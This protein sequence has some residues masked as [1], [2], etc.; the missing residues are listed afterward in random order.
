MLKKIIGILIVGTVAVVLVLVFL[1]RGSQDTIVAERPDFPFAPLTDEKLSDPDNPSRTFQLDFARVE[2]EFPV[3][4]ADLMRL[5]PANLTAL[6]QEEID[7]IYARLSA[8]PIPD[9]N[10][11]GDLFFA[12]D[13]ETGM[14]TR[15][16][17]ALGGIPGRIAEGK[18]TISEKVGRAIW[19]GKQ[20]DRENL[21]LRNF[22]EDFQ[23]FRRYIDDASALPKAKVP[24]EGYLRFILPTTSVWLMFPAKLYCGQSLLDGRRESVVI[25]YA[26]TDD[27]PGFYLGRAY[28]NRVFLVNFTL[29][30]AE[31]ANA[32]KAEFLSGGRLEED[33]YIGEQM[34]TALKQ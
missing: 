19:K 11:L 32:H 20:F 15:I 34:A 1:V 13:N 18:I 27:I 12:R 22:I 7:Q 31:V 28:I 33:C 16:Q 23:P 3:T 4:A 29:F 21:V 2:H 14:E 24:R 10:Y 17:Q 26:F 6:R 8:G 30:N 5:T 25:D 9:G